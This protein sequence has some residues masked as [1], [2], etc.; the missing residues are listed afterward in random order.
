M[1]ARSTQGL[2]I[3]IGVLETRLESRVMLR[4]EFSFLGGCII[5]LFVALLLCF[6]VVRLS[7]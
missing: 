1:S 2:V 3:G 5:S 7:C 6:V 4:I